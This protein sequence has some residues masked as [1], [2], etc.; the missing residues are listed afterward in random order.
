[1]LAEPLT[2]VLTDECLDRHA[3]IVGFEVA[4]LSHRADCHRCVLCMS[5]RRD[6]LNLG[7]ADRTLD[8]CFERGQHLTLDIAKLT[9]VTLQQL[10]THDGVEAVEHAQNLALRVGSAV[11][12]LLG[13][14]VDGEGRFRACHGIHT[15]LHTLC[16][17]C[18]RRVE[19]F[20]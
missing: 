17:L 5:G 9:S 12:H 7:I 1:M 10:L 14:V 16:S 20:Y 11:C 13:E 4:L 2:E 6:S 19:V 8:G 3:Q 15:V 18:R